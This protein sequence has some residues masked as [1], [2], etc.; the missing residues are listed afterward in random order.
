MDSRFIQDV[1]EV[2]TKVLEP[3]SRFFRQ[4]GSF[5]VIYFICDMMNLMFFSYLNHTS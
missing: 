4:K 5:I 3:K 2:D 1:I